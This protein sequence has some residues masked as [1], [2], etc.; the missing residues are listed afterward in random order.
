MCSK[1][2]L[3]RCAVLH[4]E[5]THFRSHECGDLIV[6]LKKKITLEVLMITLIVYMKS[7]ELK[8]YL[9]V[10]PSLLIVYP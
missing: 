1:V 3:Y 6:S 4:Y 7:V 8:C 2:Y 9:S 10:L 5:P